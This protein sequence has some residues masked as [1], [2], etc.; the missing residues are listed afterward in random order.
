M[1]RSDTAQVL[2]VL[3]AAFPHVLVSRETA[4]VYHE[5]LHDLD[6]EAARAA[7]R[8]LLLTAD[9]WPA[10]AT[11]RRKIAERAGVLAPTAGV[12]WGEVMGEARTVGLHGSPV[13]SHPAVAAAV[14]SIGWRSI[15]LSENPDTLRA[16][17]LKG[18]EAER[19]RCDT[20]TL[21]DSLH[22]LDAG[23]VRPAAIGAG[24]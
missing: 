12:A 17:F 14:A 23:M 11:I 19:E 16:H 9:R 13:W 4:E 18:Y 2:A 15:C 7:V 24:R 22:G 3:S 5:A 10:P 8:E 6:A 1:E 21:V 20:R